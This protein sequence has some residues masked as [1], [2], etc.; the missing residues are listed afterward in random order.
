MTCCRCKC[1]AK[2]RGL[3]LMNRKRCTVTSDVWQITTNSH[4]SCRQ[5]CISGATPKRVQSGASWN[6][7]VSWHY[8]VEVKGTSAIVCQ[9]FFRSLLNISKKRL[10]ILQDKMLCAVPITDMRGK[11]KHRPNR[12]DPDAWVLLPIFCASLPKKQTL[13]YQPRSKHE[14]TP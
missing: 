6:K 14:K 3:Q 7:R 13:F 8:T 4:C 10:E 9:Y 11:H 12:I 1:C 5:D 2:I